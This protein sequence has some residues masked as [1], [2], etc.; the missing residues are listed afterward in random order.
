MQNL[1]YLVTGA[2]GFLG[3]RLCDRLL[4]EGAEVHGTSRS[5]RSSGD[6][7][8]RWWQT[9]LLTYRDVQELFDA[10]RP[11]VVYHLAGQVTAAPDL[12]LVLPVFH[13]LLGSTLNILVASTKH[14]CRQ[15]VTTGSLTEPADAELEPIPSSPYA[16]AKWSA[17][18]YARMFHSLYQTPVVVLRPF[19]TYGPGQHETKVVPHVIDAVL[20]GNAPSLSSGN[21]QADWVY[22]DDIIEAFVTAAARPGIDGCSI[23]LGSGTLTSIRDVVRSIVQITNSNIEPQF[24]ALPDRPSQQTRVANTEYAKATLDWSVT[25]SLADGLA[26]TVAWHEAQLC[27]SHVNVLEDPVGTSSGTSSAPTPH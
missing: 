14:G 25:T 15:I 19:M 12:P 1:R 26:A 10:I 27:S 21:W 4:A 11:D 17:T 18:A 16:A 22:V 20:R 24:G 2:A 3:S 6:A 5:R 7:R 13:S 8:L 9:D 23:D